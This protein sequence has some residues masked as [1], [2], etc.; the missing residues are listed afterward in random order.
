MFNKLVSDDERKQRELM[1]KSSRG[2]ELL[3]VLDRLFIEGIICIVFAIIVLF[4]IFIFDLDVWYYALFGLLVF[5]G[6]LFIISQHN[7]RKKEYGKLN[8]NSKKKN[9]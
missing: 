5:G 1:K 9:K 2:K 8:F 3:E 4:C 7:I 6:I